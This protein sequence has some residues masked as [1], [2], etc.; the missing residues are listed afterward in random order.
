MDRVD[1]LI[2][3]FINGNLSSVKGALESLAPIEAAAFAA[4]MLERM[5]EKHRAS[6]LR[7][8]ERWSNI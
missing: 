4:Y 7:C 2:E 8:L 3:M 6:F 1:A 5:G